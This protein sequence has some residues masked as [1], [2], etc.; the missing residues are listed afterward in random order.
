M[1][2][3]LDPSVFSNSATSPFGYCLHTH[4]WCTGI[5]NHSDV[6]LF[7]SASSSMQQCE[8]SSFFQVVRQLGSIFM[9]NLMRTMSFHCSEQP[10][11]TTLVYFPAAP[12]RHRQLGDRVPLHI[13]LIQPTVPAQDMEK[14]CAQ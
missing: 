3:K 10:S 2:E 8:N 4:V 7:F 5:P 12:N 1:V 13:S 9:C 11:A 14:S 6:F